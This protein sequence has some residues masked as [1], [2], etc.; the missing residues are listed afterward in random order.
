MIITTWIDLTITLTFQIFF[1]LF[2][3]VE[4][5]LHDSCC[6][7]EEIIFEK[8]K[9]AEALACSLKNVKDLSTNTVKPIYDTVKSIA[10]GAARH[11]VSETMK[12]LVG[13]LKIQIFSERPTKDCQTDFWGF[14]QQEELV[15]LQRLLAREGVACVVCMCVWLYTCMYIHTLMYI[16]T[17]EHIYIYVHTLV[18]MYIVCMRRV[19]H[20]V[21]T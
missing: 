1:F 8:T 17:L 20:Y 4:E 19:L 12:S 9:E 7:L 13:F 6:A 18:Y 2:W 10:G 3:L 11:D 14:V 15:M 5:N 21:Q 16:Y